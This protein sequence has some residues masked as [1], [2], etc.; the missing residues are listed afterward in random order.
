MPVQA[1]AA[2]ANILEYAARQALAVQDITYFIGDKPMDSNELS[3]S[4]Q[5][6]MRL[7]KTGGTTGH[8]Q[9]G[10]NYLHYTLRI[11][12]IRLDYSFYVRPAA[13]DPVKN[14][15]AVAANIRYLINNYYEGSIMSHEEPAQ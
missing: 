12:T 3:P 13:A 7:K 2:I 9:Q 14:R 10:I 8:Q 5:L 1:S 6:S 15:N 11:P 4:P